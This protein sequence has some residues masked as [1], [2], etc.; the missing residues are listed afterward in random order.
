MNKFVF[1]FGILFLF[2]QI[3]FAE[4]IKLK[5]GK[6]IEGEI[7]ERTDEYVRIDTGN[8][9]YKIRFKQIAQGAGVVNE[10]GKRVE[11]MS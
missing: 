2:T 7:L 5:S 3:G 8:T 10:S 9:I 11:L 4:T 1:L 6:V